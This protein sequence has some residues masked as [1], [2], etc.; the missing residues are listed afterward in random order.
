MQCTDKYGENWLP[1]HAF[2]QD[3]TEY[4]HVFYIGNMDEAKVKPDSDMETNQRPCQGELHFIGI[5]QE[6]EV[7]SEDEVSLFLCC[8][9][10]KQT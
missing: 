1:F 7:D 4:I 6:E 5:K 8:A 9:T 10:V 3:V 2:P